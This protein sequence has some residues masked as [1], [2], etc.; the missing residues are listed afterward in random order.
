MA[1]LAFSGK[2]GRWSKGVMLFL[3]FL[4]KTLALNFVR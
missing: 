1:C 3:G 2:A 4:L